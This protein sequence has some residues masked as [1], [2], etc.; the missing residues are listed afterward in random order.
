MGNR[1]GHGR[2]FFAL[3]LL[4]KKSGIRLHFCKKILNGAIGCVDQGSGEGNAHHLLC[5]DFFMDGIVGKT[6]HCAVIEPNNGIRIPSSAPTYPFP[7]EVVVPVD[8]IDM[9]GVEVQ[10]EDLINKLGSKDLVAV[11]REDPVVGSEGRSRI[12]CGRGAKSTGI[13]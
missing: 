8:L 11:D 9:L 10:S 7:V 6:R 3:V 13:S 12:V 5:N 2:G 1:F 4:G